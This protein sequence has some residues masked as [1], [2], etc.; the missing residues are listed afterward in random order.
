MDSES[1]ES[2]KIYRNS[3]GQFCFVCLHCGNYS[4]NINETLVHIDS[5]FIDGTIV[6][7]NED[8]INENKPVECVDSLEFISIATETR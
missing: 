7:S 3:S 6:A 8:F 1:S 2:G 4:E 5:H